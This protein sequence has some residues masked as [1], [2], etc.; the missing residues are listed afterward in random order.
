MSNQLAVIESQVQAVV[1]PKPKRHEVIAALVEVARKD[2]A[3]KREEEERLREAALTKLR[4]AFA[5]NI[6]RKNGCRD[7]LAKKATFSAYY[8]KVY[9]STSVDIGAEDPALEKVFQE[10]KALESNKLDPFNEKRVKLMISAR[11]EGH[12]EIRDRVKAL[13]ESKEVA[14]LYSALTAPKE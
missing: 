7:T 6:R 10:W 2:H 14:A 4:A 3:T 5:K 8:E 9:V 11:L 12:P 13:S 1:A